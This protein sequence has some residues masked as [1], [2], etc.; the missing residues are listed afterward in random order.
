MDYTRKMLNEIRNRIDGLNQVEL[1]QTENIV[2]QDNLLNRFNV[3]MEE[4]ELKKKP[5]NESKDEK[6]PDGKKALVVKRNDVQ[7]GSVR[8]SQEESIRKTVGD[9][10]F[11]EDALKYYLDIEDLVLNAEISGL[12][13]TFQFRYK[14][15]SGDGCYIWAEGLQLTDSNSR[16]IE[17]IRD[18]FLNWK[19]SLVK[20]GDLLDKL[21]K[22]AKKNN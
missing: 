11:K 1:P 4:V 6:Q 15:P 22:E 13:V 5:L 7:F 17:K 8:T 16:T 19:D 12:G 21:Q 18:A 10:S 14:D 2:E 9:V 3:L 20:D